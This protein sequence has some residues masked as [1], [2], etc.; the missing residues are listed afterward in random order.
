MGRRLGSGFA[1]EGFLGVTCRLIPCS[2]F[3]YPT[4][5]LGIYNHKC[6]YPNKGTWY[7]PTGRVCDGNKQLR[8]NTGHEVC[9][10]E[11]AVERQTNKRSPSPS[12]THIVGP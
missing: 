6:G 8:P 4:L 3:G 10:P 7:E 2:F 1:L 11:T 12:S 5:V 9:I